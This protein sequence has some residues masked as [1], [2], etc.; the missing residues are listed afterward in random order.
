[1]D[2]NVGPMGLGMVEWA[3]ETEAAVDKVGAWNRWTV[4]TGING[5]SDF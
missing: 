4:T 3:L 2:C 5:N 1:M